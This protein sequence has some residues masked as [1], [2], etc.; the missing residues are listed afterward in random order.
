[1]SNDADREGG[2]GQRSVELVVALTLLLL[3][4]LVISDSLRMGIGWAD[5]G[6]R[7]GYFPFRIGVGLALCSAWV[8]L[9]QLLNW[10]SSSAG[11]ASRQQLRD[12]A[13]VFLPSVVYVALI[14]WA[15][16]YLASALL[17]GWFM[18]RH[19]G[20]RWWL[21]L[22]VSLGVS[23]LL[24]VVFERCFTQ[25]LPKGWLGALLNEHLKI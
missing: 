17:I 14:P 4:A 16:I 19:G 25:P 23:L 15:G 9:R 1:M 12:V 24:Y 13:A 8:A 10:R 18:L 7:S 5:D 3:A 2:L 20:H 11:F 22:A 6:P 21:V